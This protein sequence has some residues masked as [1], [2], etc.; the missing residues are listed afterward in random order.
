MGEE[1]NKV[2]LT[3]KGIELSNKVMSEFILDK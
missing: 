2:F 1:N 3:E